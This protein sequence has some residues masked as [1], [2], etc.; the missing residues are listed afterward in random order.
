MDIFPKVYIIILN[1][2]GWAD[3]I[4][5]LESVL[6][7][8]YT[9]Y[10]VIVIDNN[11][12]NDSME[13][14]KNWAEGKLDVLVKPDHPLRR[15]SFPPVKKPIPYV[16]YIREEAEKG[17]NIRLENKL[18]G[19]IPEGITTKYPLVFIQTGKNLGFSGGNNVGIRYAI[20]KDDFD[21]IWLINNDTVINPSTL[22]DMVHITF[23]KNFKF[24]LSNKI[25]FY[26]DPEKI[27]FLMPIFYP[28]IGI[29]I[30]KFFMKN[31]KNVKVIPSIIETNFLTGCSLLIPKYSFKDIGLLDEKIFLYNE[32]LDYSIRC[33][34]KGYKL[35]IVPN[36]FIFHKVGMSRNLSCKNYFWG[37]Y[38]IGYVYR[39]HRNFIGKYRLTTL[40][41]QTF[42]KLPIRFIKNKK[43]LLSM[44]KGAV[45]GWIK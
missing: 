38:S 25:N 5:C 15:L 22:K 43:C 11:S 8:D 36:I 45:L 2:N 16:Y 21:Y 6:R 17:G 42:I 23:N 3:T 40:L 31:T 4:E 24:L 32:D 29:V 28:F 39:K 1:Y 9:N 7:N 19:K 41:F 13:Y 35:M 18:I 44:Y 34:K 12:T 37:E 14:I 26:N 27:W 20:A 33:L 10:Q 30:D